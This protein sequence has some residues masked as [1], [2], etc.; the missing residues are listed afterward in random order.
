MTIL[1][2]DIETYSSIELT[3]HGVYKYIEAP[4]FEILLF[5]YAFDDGPVQT[6][7][8]TKEKLPQFL[9]DALLDPNII[10][11][12]YNANFER[13]CLS[14]YLG[15]K[16]PIEQWRCSSIHAL[17]LGL[18]GWLDGVAQAL[19]LEQQK[20]SAGKNL[21]NYFSKPCKPT[22]SNGGRTRNLPRHDPEKWQAFIRYNQQDVE[23]E[24]AV[25]KVLE[26]YPMPESE[27]RLWFIDQEITDRG[28]RIDPVLVQH[29][30]RCSEL[31]REKLEAEAVKLTGL[32]NPNS[33][34]QLKEW[35]EKA[36]GLEIESLNKKAI[37][38]LM[39][40]VESATAERVLELRQELSKTS[41]RKYQAMERAM[42]QDGRARGLLQFYGA[43][44]TGRW[45]GRII[46]VQNLP[47]NNM[48]DLDLARKL[49]RAG[50]YESLELLFESVPDTLSQ[51]I[52]TA[53]IPAEGH[54]FIVA[55]FSS[56]EA[57]VVAWLAGEKWRMDVFNS[58]GKIY[59]MSAAQMFKV[60]FESIDKSS[61]LRQKGKVAELAC[62]AEGQ[63]V[64]TDQG[65][66]PIEKITTNHKVWDGTEFVTH[67][68]VVFR[69]IKEVITY[70]GLCATPDHK[71]WIEGEPE[72]VQLQYAAACGARLLRSGVGWQ[73]LRVGKDY[74][75]GK[76]LGQELETSPSDHSM[77]RMWGRTMDAIKQLAT[78]L[79]QRLPGLFA[80][81]SNS[82]MAG[83]KVGSGKTALHQPKRSRLPQLWW[84][85]NRIP[86]SFCFGGRP[87]DKG[88]PGN[89]AARDGD[90][91]D[92]QQQSLRTRQ[93]SICNAPKEREQQA[94]HQ[95]PG[96]GPQEM[97]LC[98]K[99]CSTKTKPR[100]DERRNHPGSA[101]SS[102]RKTQKLEDNCRKVRV[103]DILNAGPRNRYTVSD[104]LVHN[105]GYGGGVGAIKA[106]GA[107]EMGLTEDELPDLV[108]TWRAANPSITKFWW[109]VE[110][111]A[112]DAVKDRKIT[113]LQYGLTFS[114]ESGCLFITLP[115]G[116][117]LAYLRP[118]I[119]IDAR[120]NKPQ[121]TYEGI[122][123]KLWKHLK[124]Y[125]PKL[126][127][128]IVQAVSRDCLATAIVRLH[129][130][131]YR[132]VFHV[133]DEVIAEMPFGSGSVEEM[134]EIMGQPIEWAPGLPL[135]ADGFE[136]GYYQKD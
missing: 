49:L 48:P 82:K 91:P 136:C 1:S 42:G 132:I 58:H 40:E 59:E 19:K 3:T 134:C 69:G 100:Y 57:R 76:A 52:R 121:L 64:L 20:D 114:Y 106:M 116:R 125:G 7:D 107:L 104:C 12:A 93:P 21:I 46:N 30:I 96:L 90:R 31:H 2:V 129:E 92:R 110:A 10:K 27:W 34:V 36:E 80:T 23:V 74:K 4:D 68:G 95:N 108:K 126:V 53:I 33:V 128:N 102:E 94:K 50:D 79:I 123:Q 17:Y 62:I 127:E 86:L 71:V 51:L 111:A 63:L 65:L 101:F 85:R 120:Y 131:G 18:P 16:L 87:L 25:R 22:K 41:I 8:L 73:A 83:S 118:K 97:A 75:S 99:R 109:D 133:H 35:F 105:C 78:R 9:I 81:A 98:T 5:S 115:S 13:V 135:R 124:T 43:N 55:D 70:D 117:R 103:Y 119:E 61:P 32:E 37:P 24:R 26:K 6:I 88:K 112:H 54:R 11:S 66:V 130:A 113:V 44:R 67:D 28:V 45:A 47:R 84:K 56:I 15:I 77:C 39:K 38:A 89:T 60:P 72:P 122:E 14:K 29:A